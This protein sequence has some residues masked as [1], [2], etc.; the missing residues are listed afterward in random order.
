MQN[1]ARPCRLPLFRSIRFPF[2]LVTHVSLFT[3]SGTHMNKDGMSAMGAV[4]VKGL[5]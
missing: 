4:A 2:V 5:R 1:W 3:H